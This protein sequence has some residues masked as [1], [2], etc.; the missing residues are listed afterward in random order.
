MR[1][2]LGIALVGMVVASLVLAG[3]GTLVLAAVGDRAATEEDLRE[4]VEA[5]SALLEELSFAPSQDDAEPV[6]DR[7]QRI[8]RTISVEGIG[9]VVLPR[10]GGAPIGELPTGILTDDL[11][12]AAL[13]D[14][15]T[16]S[17]QK[18]DLIWA[19]AGS[20]NRAGVPQLLVIT[21]DADPILLPAFRWFL[22][23]SVVTIGLAVLVTVRVSRR[24]TDPIR[25]ASSTA[26]QIAAGDLSSRVADRHAEIGGEVGELV[27]SINAMATNLDRSRSLERQF[28]LSVSHDL[29]TPLTSIRGY[30]EALSDGAVSDPEH[31]G[32]IIESEAK[33]LERLV[34]DL[35]LLARLESTG[36]E[37]HIAETD[38]VGLVRATSL[39]LQREAEARGVAMTVR[40]PDSI[41]PIAVDPDRYAQVVS[42]LIGNS[43]RFADCTAVVTL[44][45][46]EGRIHLSVGDD[47]PGIS[48]EDLPYVFERLYVAQ[49][50]PKAEESG[51]GLGLAIVRELVEGMGGA[52]AA[53][54]SPIGGA[55][56]VVSFRPAASAA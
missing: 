6:R 2:R 41:S 45:E 26:A 14:G 16:I 11:D 29:R 38:A 22:I 13:Q 42:N 49:N 54:R 55:E 48:D 8:A 28:L 9:I 33:R 35:L 51:S 25:E 5:F 15:Q 50:S 20:T 17:G 53:R 31:T 19:A 46:A 24:L 47:G 12:V 7:L 40:V 1:R 4:Q 10:N 27:T 18:G 3:V 32:S 39:S 52:V 36:F 44:W 43:L 56:I 34:G 30:A 37:Y 21:R 23:A